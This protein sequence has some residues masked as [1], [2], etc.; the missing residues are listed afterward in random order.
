MNIKEIN[1][2]APQFWVCLLGLFVVGGFTL[3]GFF[4]Y[5]RLQHGREV[6]RKK[7]KAA[8]DGFYKMA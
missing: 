2:G 6:A 5:Q 3:A 8:N 1:D 4:G 7:A